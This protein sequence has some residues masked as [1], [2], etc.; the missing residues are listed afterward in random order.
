MIEGRTVAHLGEQHVVQRL[1]SANSGMLRRFAD[2]L[3]EH[4]KRMFDPHTCDDETVATYVERNNSGADASFLLVFEDVAIAYFFLWEAD[5][6]VPVLGIGIA[7]AYQNGGLGKKLMKLLIE[8]A[9]HLGKSGID[10]TTM[11]DNNRAFHLYERCGFY[12]VG[13]VSNV[14]GDG[15]QVTERRM[16]FRIADGAQPPKRE[17]GPPDSTEA[18]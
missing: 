16:F 5:Q 14:T 8:E 18:H 7:D 13:D 15:R 12:Y 1:S 10:L 9:T 3:G 2:S 6:D 17:F 11:Q 4:S